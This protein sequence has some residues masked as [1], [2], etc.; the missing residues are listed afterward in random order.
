MTKKFNTKYTKGSSNAAERTRL[1]AEISAI[2]DKYRG[3]KKKRKKKGFPPAVEK[4]LKEL[5]KKRDEL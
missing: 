4:R 2:Y 1:M 3:T 5:M